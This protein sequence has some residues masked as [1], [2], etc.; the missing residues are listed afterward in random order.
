MITG[1]RR[2][3]DDPTILGQLTGRVMNLALLSL[4]SHDSP[5]Q[6][7]IGLLILCN[8]TFPI[9]TVVKD[10]S[11]V[12]GGAAMQIAIQNGLHVSGNGQ[13]FA[14]TCLWPNARECAFRSRLWA[15]CLVTCQRSVFREFD[16]V[17]LTDFAQHE[18]L[19]WLAAFYGH[20]IIRL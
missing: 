1:A 13:D 16:V 2:Y 19:R 18:Y 3:L 11:H 4:S 5:L 20:R 6:T 15:F 7:V 9:D 10:L 12:F 14:R 17:Y 8:W